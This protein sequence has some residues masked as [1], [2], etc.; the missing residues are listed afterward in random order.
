S[1]SRHATPIQGAAAESA[2]VV[3]NA[4]QIFLCCGPTTAFCLELLY[5]LEQIEWNRA[6]VAARRSG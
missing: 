6:A 1:E 5:P 2:R 3:A 4:A